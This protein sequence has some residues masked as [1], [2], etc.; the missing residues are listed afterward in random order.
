VLILLLRICLKIVC[1]LFVKALLKIDAIT[2]SQALV[3]ASLTGRDFRAPER[4]SVLCPL[5]NKPVT[6]DI[7]LATLLRP[8]ATVCH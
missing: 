6:G 8:T 7:I 1:L 4:F 5:T 2:Q 3:T